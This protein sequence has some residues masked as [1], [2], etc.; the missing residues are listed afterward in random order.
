MSDGTSTNLRDINPSDYY[1][2]VQSLDNRIIA[3]APMENSHNPRVIALAPGQG[4]LLRVSLEMVDRCTQ[5]ISHIPLA[6][7]NANVLVKFKGSKRYGGKQGTFQP[8]DNNQ[9]NK[10]DERGIKLRIG[11]VDDN[12]RNLANIALQDDQGHYYVNRDTNDQYAD[13]KMNIASLPRSSVN[14]QERD[15][16][17]IYRANVTPLEI[18]MYVLLT[19]FCAA[20]AVFV[21]SCFVYVSRIRRQDYTLPQQA[22]S[23]VI[24]KTMSST[25]SGRKPRSVQNAHDWVWLGKNAVDRGDLEESL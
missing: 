17:F 20:M 21:A 5:K 7:Q 22:L 3:F 6:V 23:G 13:E 8:D 16:H 24:G 15:N 25:M 14:D 2:S 11:L 1:L 9:M 18:G 10:K 4:K 19:V 12:A